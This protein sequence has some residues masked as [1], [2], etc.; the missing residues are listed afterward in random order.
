[1]YRAGTVGA[2]KRSE[3][4][5]LGS[6]LWDDEWGTVNK[7]PGKVVH[8]YM[9]VMCGMS[10]TAA[11]ALVPTGGPF[12]RSAPALLH[13]LTWIVLTSVR[14]LSGVQAHGSVAAFA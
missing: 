14:D 4:L 9:S 8:V 6:S 1:M 10:I 7:R 13:G 2:Q 5:G 11:Q 3:C 12:T